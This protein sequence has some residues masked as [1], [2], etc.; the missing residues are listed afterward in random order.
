[1]E[2]NALVIPCLSCYY[3][4]CSPFK[5]GRFSNSN[6]CDYT[7]FQPSTLYPAVPYENIFLTFV[8]LKLYQSYDRKD[9]RYA[10]Q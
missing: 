4:P 1:M 2:T 8:A 7:T 9:S 6:N 10:H 5:N 3:I